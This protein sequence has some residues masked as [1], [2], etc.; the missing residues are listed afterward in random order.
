M[1]EV[2]GTEPSMLW[3]ALVVFRAHAAS[4]IETSA[5]PSTGDRLVTLLGAAVLS[6]GPLVVVALVLGL[7]GSVR[8][9]SGPDQLVP[10]LRLPALAVLTWELAGVAGGGSY[11]LHYLVG[12]V[13]GMVLLA[14]AAAQRGARLRRSTGAALA[15]AVTS[16]LAAHVVVANAAPPDAADL[17]VATYLRSHESPGDTVVV[18]FGHPDI[19]Y[20]SGLPSPY[21]QLWSLPV[22]VRDSSLAEL[23]RVLRGRHAPT[24]VVVSGQSLA[25]WGVDATTAQRVLDADYQQ[26][27]S[28]GPYV[29]WHR[30]TAADRAGPHQDNASHDRHARGSEL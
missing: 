1:A 20:E 26:A 3:D 16:C 19:V 13:P 2:R 14:V 6:G 18:G 5:S 4:V 24:W 7:R 22:R 10:D 27:T 25:T 29:I 12:L 30:A 8:A 9:H 21:E 17:S 11:W 15:F 23:T 28:V